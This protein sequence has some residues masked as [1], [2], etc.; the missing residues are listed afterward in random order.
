MER[1][2]CTAHPPSLVDPSR[3]SYGWPFSCPLCHW[4]GSFWYWIILVIVV[5]IWIL[6][7]K[8]RFFLQFTLNQTSDWK[9]KS[10][11]CSSYSSSS[12]SSMVGICQVTKSHHNHRG[13]IPTM[14]GICHGGNVLGNH[15]DLYIMVRC[16]CVCLY[17]TKRHHSVLKG[18]GRFTRL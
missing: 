7:K 10:S 12:L 11:K 13:Q 8:N 9:K 14:V 5:V 3:E 6:F 15:D 1:G 4:T 16:L 17:V 18:F 2:P